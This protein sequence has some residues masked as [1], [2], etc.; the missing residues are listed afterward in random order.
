MLGAQADVADFF[1][2]SD[3]LLFASR[4]DG[5]ESMNASVIEAGILGIP[6]AAYAVG[7]VPEIVV[8]KVTGRLTRHGDID[9]LAAC[10]LELFED[11]RAARAMGEAARERYLSRYDIKV[12]APMYLDL[13]KE[14]IHS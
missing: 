11:R 13:Y 5:M 1:V 7:G 9:G 4:P 3:V 14:L 8:D 6:A 2:A 10:V 12:I